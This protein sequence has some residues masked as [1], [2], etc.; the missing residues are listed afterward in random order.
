MASSINRRFGYHVDNGPTGRLP[1]RGAAGG[2]HDLSPTRCRCFLAVLLARLI[3]KNQTQYAPFFET[4]IRY[5]GGL[6]SAYA[7]SGDPILLS[8][9]DDLGKMLLPAFNTTS[10]LP[11]YAVNTVT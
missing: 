2:Q 4:V 8:R 7:L 3:R 1:G 6:L 9:A 11:I 10:G 5:L